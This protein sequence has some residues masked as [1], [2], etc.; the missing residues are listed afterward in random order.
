MQP[1]FLHE[2][3]SSSNGVSKMDEEHRDV[4]V[5]VVV[6]SAAST[7]K[8]MV[9]QIFLQKL[10]YCATRKREL[11]IARTLSTLDATGYS[12][13]RSNALSVGF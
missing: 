9:G 6:G 3:Q 12:L 13:L 5:V 8:R 10:C 1:S 7:E 4:A 11:Q 2:Q